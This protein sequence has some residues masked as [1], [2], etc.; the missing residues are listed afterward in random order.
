MQTVIVCGHTGCGGVS[1]AYDIASGE[2][3]LRATATK[4]PSP[5]SPLSLWLA[6]LVQLA[7]DLHLPPAP[8]EEALPI[9]TRAN[10]QRQIENVK[11]AA[12]NMIPKA[13]EGVSV[14]GWLYVLE[15]G[16]LQDLNMSST[17]A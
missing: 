3:H 11:K 6:P 1:A 8:P 15:K 14:H 16:L 9:L 10:I 17:L 7:L 5:D 12:A 13:E 4:T 2:P